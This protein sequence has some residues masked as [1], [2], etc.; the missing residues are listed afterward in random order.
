MI[1]KHFSHEKGIFHRVLLG[2]FPL[3]SATSN[4]DNRKKSKFMATNINS[5][6]NGTYEGSG[7]SE[8]FVI[9]GPIK[10]GIAISIDGGTSDLNAFGE[11][12]TALPATLVAT[13][14]DTNVQ[15]ALSY[16]T[17]AIVN[18]VY[19]GAYDA[20]NSDNVTISTVAS[21]LDTPN[22]TDVIKFTKSGDYSAVEF[23][24]IEQ[25]HLA[26]GVSITLSS[27]QLDTAIGSL[28]LGPVN[29]GLNFYGVAGGKQETVNVTVNYSET[30][31]TPTY[32]GATAINFLLG[33]FQL[34]DAS[35]G[36][37][38]HNV[39]HKD[40]FASEL[41][42]INAADYAVLASRADGSHNNDYG[43]GGKGIDYATLRLGNDEY[44]GGAGNDLLIGHQGADK[45]YGDTGNDY[46]L[47]TS[48]GGRFGANGKQDDGNKEWVSGDL[49]NGG[50]G[51]DTLRITGGA[52][53]AQTI[54]LT[55]SNFK[56]MEVVE[57]G[58]TITASNVENVYLQVANGHYDLNAAGSLNSTASTTT[59]THNLKV[60]QSADFVK[61]D[62]SSITANG[63]SFVGNANKNTF[64]G[65]HQADS[66]T[67]NGG[68]DTLTGGAGADTFIYGKVLTNTASGDK[69]TIAQTYSE[70]ATALTGTDI[71]TDFNSGTDKLQLNMDQYSAFSSAGSIASGNL[72]QGAGATAT[73]SSEFL[74]FDSSS[75]TLY[76]DADGSGS[77]A[78]VAIVTLTGVSSLAATDFVI[79]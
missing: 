74:I 55:D 71:I 60:G 37:L 76:Y 64:I 48:F 18:V 36:Y 78:Q 61:V 13:L 20:A 3:E 39:A 34:D 45:L 41:E 67:G 7:D 65:T 28:D 57:V 38:F 24:H 5:K 47:I 10:S 51:I 19:T 77:G 1:D 12:G 43:T 63:L 23:T 4:N 59:G 42:N 75:H 30:S 46:F 33:D 44:H 17:D 52:T 26:S 69:N 62:A 11:T 32:T 50:D 25:L 68:N 27:E 29:P 15:T 16:V 73:S 8:T 66:F 56:N 70:V 40:D 31:F 22:A 79:A 53:K 6:K 49:I 21:V 72:V 58:A 54:K 14:T 2:I 9:S 35:S